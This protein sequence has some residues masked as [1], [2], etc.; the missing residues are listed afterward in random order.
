MRFPFCSMGSE[1][2][3]AA[4]GSRTKEPAA[5]MEIRSQVEVCPTQPGSP[6]PHPPPGKPLPPWGRIDGNNG[7]DTDG[8]IDRNSSGV[9]DGRIRSCLK[10]TEMG[11]NSRQ[12]ECRFRLG[13]GQ[14]ERRVEDA[15]EDSN[16]SQF[17][18]GQ[19]PLFIRLYLQPARCIVN[20]TFPRRVNSP[21]TQTYTM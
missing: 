4:A 5:T 17:S 14:D 2:G 10:Q 15:L 12:V 18:C 13:S 9:W 6:V 8:L 11:N 20:G 21:D 19:S 1:L 16:G 7:Y 3:A